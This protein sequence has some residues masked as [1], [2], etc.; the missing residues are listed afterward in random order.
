MKLGIFDLQAWVTPGGA[1]YT[2]R[3]E[4]R[5]TMAW[6]LRERREIAGA[7]ISFR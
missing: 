1:F 2:A 6:K 7:V 3:E 4:S 5:L